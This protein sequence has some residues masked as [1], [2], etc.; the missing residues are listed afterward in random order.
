MKLTDKFQKKSQNR[1]GS[2]ASATLAAGFAVN[3]LL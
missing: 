1:I 3:Y 2:S